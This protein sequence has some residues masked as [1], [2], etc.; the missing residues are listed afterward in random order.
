MVD[1]L[2]TCVLLLIMLSASAFLIYRFFPTAFPAA[3]PAFWRHAHVPNQG[4]IKRDW[5]ATGRIDFATSL[6]TNPADND[7]PIEFKLL[8]EERR[9]V[10]SIAGN[11]NLE[12]QWRLATLREAKSVVTQY[13]KYLSDNSLIKTVFDETVSLPSPVTQGHSSDEARASTH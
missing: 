8:V 13:H 11:E 6:T 5:V 7:Q 12:I 2:I 9:I 3:F 10:E 4:V 1:V